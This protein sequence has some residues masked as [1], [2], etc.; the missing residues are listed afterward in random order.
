[1]TNLILSY[2]LIS[3][4]ILIFV[5][6]I[7]YKLNLVDIPNKR[8]KHLNPTAYT[9]GL[10]LSF[11]YIISILLFDIKDEKLNLILPI[12]FLI[13]IVGFIDDI[14]HLNISGKLGLQVFAIVYLIILENFNLNQLGDYN[15]FKLELSSVSIPFTLL[16][17]VFLINSFNYFDGLDGTL[18]FTTISVLV[19]LYFLIT[20][21]NIKFFLIT[22]L[23]PLLFFLF[24]NFSAF[25]LP[26]L[27]LGDSGS[28]LIGFIIAFTLIFIG[29]SGEVHPILLAWSVTIFVYE[30]L[31]VHLIRLKN[32]KAA[33]KAGLDHLHHILF[34]KTKTLFLTNFLIS[35]TNIIF[36]IIGYVSFKFINPLTSLILFLFLFMIY[37]IVRLNFLNNKNFH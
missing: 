33:F 13:A 2:S 25:K 34:K 15:Y 1:M 22:I 32:K 35:I 27:F 28:L 4:L 7:S 31:S 29:N 5:A 8:K 30:F 36:F 24:F 16:A 3:F 26:K 18:S 9:G 23:I 10:A 17:V 37:F 14:Y 21:E 11:I 6:K 12:A 19:I 20:D